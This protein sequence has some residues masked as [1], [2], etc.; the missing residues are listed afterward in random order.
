MFVAIDALDSYSTSTPHGAFRGY[1]NGKVLVGLKGLSLSRQSFLVWIYIA[2]VY[3]NLEMANAVYGIAAVLSGVASPR[4][5][6]MS[7]GDLKEMYTLRNC[8]S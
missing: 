5:C 2:N 6:P 8:W 1:E 7:F 3:T 4:D